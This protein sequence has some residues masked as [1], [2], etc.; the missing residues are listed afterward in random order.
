MNKKELRTVI[1]KKRDDLN[2][3]ERNRMD[4][5]ILDRLLKSKM[6]KNSMNIFVFVNYGSEVDTKS[7]I[8]KAIEDGKRVCIPKTIR[9]T[10]EMKA[11]EIK[12]LDNLK[13]DNWGILEPETFQGEINKEFLDLIIVPGV[14]FDRKGN[15]IGYG[16]GYYDRYFSDLNS[17]IK[18]V[19]LAYDMQVVESLVSEEHDVK[20]EYI[21]TEKEIIECEI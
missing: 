2:L 19:V 16:G 4:D 12:S 18:K 3:K 17:K 7:F 11:V 15:R 5:L 21:I 9:N 6:Y 10:R 1:I 20:V 14:V 13:P 8:Y